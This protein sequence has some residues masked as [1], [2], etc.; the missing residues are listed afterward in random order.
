MNRI[1][2]Y[3]LIL[4]LLFVCISLLMKCVK[5][6]NEKYENENDKRPPGPWG[7]IGQG[8]PWYEYPYT[9]HNIEY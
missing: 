5:R 6:S 7:T 1:L 3:I 9:L 4:L 2:P 8:N